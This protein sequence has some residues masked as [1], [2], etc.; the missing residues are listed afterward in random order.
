MSSPKVCLVIGAGDATGGAVAKRFAREGYTVCATRRSLDKLA[1]LL[2]EI[3]AAGGVAHGFASDARKEEEVIALVEEIES[4]IGPIEVMVF[5]IGANSPNS[6]LTETARRYTKMWE[7]ACL[8]GF[9]TGRE[10]AKRMV[11]RPESATQGRSHKGTIIFTGAT[12]SLRGSANFA[13]FSG[14]KMALRALAQSMAREL[15]P[16]GVHVA[17]TII[18]GAIDTEFIRTQFPQRYALKDEGGILNPDHIADAYWMLHQ[19]PRDAWT[20]ELDLRPYM[21][22]F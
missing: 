14:G 4:S 8:A 11:A 17:H 6:I 12:A 18:D 20:H 10:A 13:G 22:N 3:R 19:Q 9:L 7:M 16:M 5:N 15:G 2:A 1:P 21:E